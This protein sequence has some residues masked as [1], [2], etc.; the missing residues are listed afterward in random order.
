M[1]KVW[2]LALHGG[3]GPITARDPAAAER[4]MGET[5]DQG[6]RALA[7]GARA[8]DVVQRMVAALELSGFHVAGRG[9]SPNQLGQWELDAAIM[10]GDTRRAGAV[11]ALRGFKSPVTAARCVLDHSPHVL[12]VG[13]GASRFLRPHGLE[14]VW[15]PNRYYTPAV[16]RPVQRG[17]LAHGT[18]G[19]VALDT[20]GCLAA[21]TSTGG[22][23]NK[24]PGRVG[25]TPILGAGTWADERVAVS[26]TGQ[27]EFFQRAVVA[28]DVSARVRYGRQ[29]LDAAARAA[30]EDV[31]LLGG[32]GGLIAIDKLGTVCL[33]FLSEGMKR[34]VATSRGQWEVATRR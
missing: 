22:L 13:K 28:S 34:A 7:Q 27:G 21:A 5:L 12:L 4:H 20:E 11:A 26:C 24:T 32:D 25:D 9:A 31:R 15:S 10:E 18:V 3:A 17:E 29:S 23:L 14:R 8:V 1:G 19:A 6:A 16:S 33:P 2:S 30:L